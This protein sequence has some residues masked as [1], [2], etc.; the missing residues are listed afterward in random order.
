MRNL[1]GAIVQIQTPLFSSGRVRHTQKQAH[2]T[3]LH[4]QHIIAR[5]TGKIA[6]CTNR[7]AKSPTPF[8]QAVEGSVYTDAWH[9]SKY[10]FKCTNNFS[11]KHEEV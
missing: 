9:V 2:N 11:T 6:N 4:A 8:V 5:Q 10:M 7:C 1:A 3:S